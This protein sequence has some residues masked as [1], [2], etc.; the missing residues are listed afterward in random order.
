[1]LELAWHASWAVATQIWEGSWL[2][3]TATEAAR[4]F[5]AA[6]P[7]PLRC[8]P[9]CRRSMTEFDGLCSLRLREP[10]VFEGVRYEGVV[11]V[12]ATPVL[13]GGLVAGLGLRFQSQLHV[14]ATQW[15][16]RQPMCCWVRRSAAQQRTLLC[17]CNCIMPF[18][19]LPAR[20]PTPGGEFCVPP[21]KLLPCC[22]P[23]LLA[24]LSAN[25]TSEAE[26]LV[27]D[28]LDAALNVSL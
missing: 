18:M 16:C 10:C 22:L 19:G 12:Q 23:L 17:G 24:V 20:L 2:T 25:E 9:S 5:A 15:P 7:E 11:A 28:I 3:N 8:S 27:Q 26:S 14:M 13:S 21:P 1:M 4:P 6:L